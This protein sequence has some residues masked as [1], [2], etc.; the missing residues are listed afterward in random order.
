MTHHE[1][2]RSDEEVA[3]D[4]NLHKKVEKAIE[5]TE[6]VQAELCALSK[7]TNRQ[8]SMISKQAEMQEKQAQ[9]IAQMWD[10]IKPVL[11]S[12]QQKERLKQEI[13][14]KIISGGVWGTVVGLFL[15]IWEGLKFYLRKG[16]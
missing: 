1:D 5:L 9:M 3:G 7:M 11:T 12:A 16:S 6:R 14:Q 2:V 13:M 10:D 8:A 15:L 4:S